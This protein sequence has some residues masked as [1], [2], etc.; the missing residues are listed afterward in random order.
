MCDL[1][2]L[3]GWFPSKI[4]TKVPAITLDATHELGQ[5]P[6]GGYA[7]LS[8]P[9]QTLSVSC[10]DR[11]S[12]PGGIQA[13]NTIINNWEPESS[14][15]ACLSLLPT[16]GG[17]PN[18]FFEWGCAGEVKIIGT[19]ILTVKGIEGSL[20]PQTVDLSLNATNQQ[21]SGFSIDR[22]NLFTGGIAPLTTYVMPVA[23]EL[24]APIPA[25]MQT[26][27]PLNTLYLAANVGNVDLTIFE[28]SL[29]EITIAIEFSPASVD[30]L[31]IRP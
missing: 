9:S 28:A 24:N 29:S 13:R 22:Q 10:I 18:A 7:L 17:S 1:F 16:S 5:F 25:V 21:G 15:C 31:C 27:A 26:G 30:C 11:F 14:R 12:R 6:G 3:A 23:F 8:P 20:I 2:H 19:L 4:Q